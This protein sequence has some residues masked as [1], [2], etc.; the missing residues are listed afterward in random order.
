M[1]R[2]GAEGAK[3]PSGPR[4]R[5]VRRPGEGGRCSSGRGRSAAVGRQF[6]CVEGK[7]ETDPALDRRE[8][9][10]QGRGRYGEDGAVGV[11][12]AVPGDGGEQRAAKRAA[13]P[14]PD[15][16]EIVLTGA[17]HERGPGRALDDHGLERHL[18]PVGSEGR[19]ERVEEPPRLS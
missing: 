18:G 9:A 7:V 4:R 15:H 8:V 19:A 11:G 5:M 14:G 12:D 13:A 16:Q 1:G 10:H 17:L 6:P 2:V 3:R